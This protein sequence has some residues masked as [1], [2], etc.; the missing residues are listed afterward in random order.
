M[1]LDHAIS[2]VLAALSA[3]GLAD[4]LLFI[5]GTT[6]SRTHLP[7]L[8]LSEDVDLITTKDRGVVGPAIEQAVAGGLQRS[9]G[10]VV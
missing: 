7:T 6:L 1:L 8:R 10:D 9:H 3:A 4:T 2:H 5:G